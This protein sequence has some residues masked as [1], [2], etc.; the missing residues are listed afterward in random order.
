MAKDQV[1]EVKE[2][3]DILEIV[4]E[5]VTLKR[6]GR[7][8]KGLCPFHSEKSPSFIVSPERQSYKCFGCGEGGDVF[9][10]LQK[11]EGMSFLESLESLA[12]RV[13]VEIVSYR[14]TEADSYKKTILTVLSLASEYYHYLLTK[15]DTGEH[16]RKYLK[17]RGITNDSIKQF[18][19][20]YEI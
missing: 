18:Y 6:A 13:G 4:G 11:Y 1:E 3:I 2:K 17:D 9:S 20:G 8:Y 12:K 7:H 19:L 16:A 15:H 10:F 14:A 5:R